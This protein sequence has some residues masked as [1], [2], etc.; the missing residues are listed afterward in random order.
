LLVTLFS[1][2]ALGQETLSVFVS[3][4]PQKYFVEKIGGSHVTVHVMVGPGQN[5]VTYEPTIKQM[6]ALHRS[7]LYHRIGIGFEKAWMARITAA[8]P[9]MRVVDARDAIELRRMETAAEVFGQ[10]L[11]EPD[12]G[13]EQDPHFWTDPMLVK[14]VSRQLMEQFTAMD[15]AH[16]NAYESH[17]RHFAAELDALHADIKKLL[18]DKRGAKFMVFHPA[19]GYFAHTY[20]LRQVPIELQGREPGAKTLA[21]LID[22]ARTNGIRVLIVQKQ[23]SRRAATT[24]AAAIHGEV[25][26]IDPMQE[27][28]L[29]SMRWMAA[30]IAGAAT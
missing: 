20:G 4:T 16:K 24:I 3:I 22:Y 25:V 15:P 12:H 21:A 17:F 30:V 5:P 9:D 8:N 1:H 2:H 11:H 10:S 19:W 14:A 6:A 28:Y 29:Q 13:G 7:V 23:F 18:A 27:N 26:S